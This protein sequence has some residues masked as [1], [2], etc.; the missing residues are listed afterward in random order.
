MCK[1]ASV[2]IN[3]KEP[4]KLLIP[5]F[6]GFIDFLI[7][8]QF[9]ILNFDSRAALAQMRWTESPLSREKTRKKNIITNCLK[10]LPKIETIRHNTQALI[11]IVE[12]DK[13]VFN[14]SFEPSEC[15][16]KKSLKFPWKLLFLLFLIFLFFNSILFVTWLCLSTNVLV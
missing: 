8:K 13:I 2:A 12:G 16:K 4:G 5:L 10:S 1:Q 9:V 11:K 3:V 6:L 7:R 14:R 15:L